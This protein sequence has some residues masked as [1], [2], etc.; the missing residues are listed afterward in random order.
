MINTRFRAALMC[1]F[2]VLVAFLSVTGCAVLQQ[3]VQAPE[4]AVTD[5]R[6]AKAG[7]LQQVLEFDLELENPNSFALPLAAMNYTLEISG[8]EIGKGS[9][10]K[11]LTLPA[12]GQAV[13][14]ITFKVNSLDLLSNVLQH[15]DFQDARYRVFGNF[16]FSESSRLPAI[17][18]ERSGRV[19]AAE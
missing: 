10:T 6:L 8:I 4:V 17:P 16:R 7:L 12:N 3:L 1:R 15:G 19:G 14:P 18:F 2:V 9:H 13:W 5:V 11:A